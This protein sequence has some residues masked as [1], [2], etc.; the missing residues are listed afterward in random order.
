MPI[1]TLWYVT[2]RAVQN[3]WKDNC[4]RLGSLAGLLHRLV[5]GAAGAAHR[6]RGRAR[7]RS[8]GLIV[9]R[10]SQTQTICAGGLSDAAGDE[11]LHP[12][13]SSSLSTID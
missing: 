6:W 13:E 1:A 8:F 4:L 7:A 2:L 3:W 12:L 5:P 9:R 11:S 10:C